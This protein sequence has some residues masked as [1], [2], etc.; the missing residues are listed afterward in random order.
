[1]IYGLPHFLSVF[2]IGFY[3]WKLDNMTKPDETDAC[4]LDFQDT[5]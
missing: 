5:F 2:D 1:M 3:I 4:V